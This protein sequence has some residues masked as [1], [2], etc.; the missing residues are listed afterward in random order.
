ML[1]SNKFYHLPRSFFKSIVS[2]STSFFLGRLALKHEPA[3][4][5]RVF[6]IVDGWTQSILKPLHDF[7]FSILSNIEQDGTFNQG[8]PLE[9]LISKKLPFLGSYDLSAATDRLPIDLQVSI[10]SELID[11][12]FARAWKGLLVDRK[13]YLAK[14]KEYYSYAVGQPMGAL[15]S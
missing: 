2:G 3:Q 6:A 11:E 9:K 8:A 7:L 1:E 15:S 10:L 12:K 4:K 13:Y 14:T 5:V